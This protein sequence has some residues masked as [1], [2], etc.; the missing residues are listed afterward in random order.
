MKILSGKNNFADK[1]MWNDT[2]KQGINKTNWRMSDVLAGKF[3][4]V[5]ENGGNLHIF[6]QFALEFTNI[7]CK[8]VN[9]ELQKFKYNLL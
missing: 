8:S 9:M 6:K 5:L 3:K 1:P 4:V 2:H 7:H